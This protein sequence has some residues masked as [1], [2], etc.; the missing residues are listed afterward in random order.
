[1]AGPAVAAV[2]ALSGL[3]LTACGDD[4]AGNEAGADVQDVTEDDVAVGPYDGPYDTAFYGDLDSYVGEEVTVSAD[5]NEILSPTSFTIAGTDDTTV[6]PLLVVGATEVTGL[7]SDLTVSVTGT[8]QEGFDVAAVEDDLG[9]DLD[10]ELYTEWDGEHYLVAK[11]VDTSVS[12][13]Q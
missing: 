9:A 5:V 11:S 2:L 4:T 13:D 10:D 1:M 8:V 7:E 12:A 6:E 3:G